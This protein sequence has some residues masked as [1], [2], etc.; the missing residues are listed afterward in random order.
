MEIREKKRG[1]KEKRVGMNESCVREYPSAP[2]KCYL[3]V[4]LIV[5]CIQY[6]YNNIIVP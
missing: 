1:E 3:Y 4:G 5:Y 6:V 2:L